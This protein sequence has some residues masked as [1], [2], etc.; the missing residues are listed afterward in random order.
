[1]KEPTRIHGIIEA[2]HVGVAEEYATIRHRGKLHQFEPI[3][4]GEYR[5]GRQYP[6][7]I[8]DD[9]LPSDRNGNEEIPSWG[10]NPNKLTGGFLRSL[11]IERIAITAQT[12]V[13]DYVQARDRRKFL[14]GVRQ[15]DD[16]SRDC[17]E[18]VE[19]DIESSDVYE[20]DR[21]QCT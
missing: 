16:I 7:G 15:R 13:F 2:C 10:E 18:I 8:E 14:V 9:P 4:H 6:V 21:D 17:M 3:E 11:R 12:Y 1:M 19:R 5:R 20:S